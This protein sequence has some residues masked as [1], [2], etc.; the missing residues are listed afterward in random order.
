MGEVK[1]FHLLMANV[2]AFAK[3]TRNIADNFFGFA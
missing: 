2:N 3:I 1:S